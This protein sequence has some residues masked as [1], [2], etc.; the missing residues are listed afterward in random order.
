MTWSGEIA[1]YRVGTRWQE[2]RAVLASHQ[3]SDLVTVVEGFLDDQT[4]DAPG[5]SDHHDL[6]EDGW[7]MAWLERLRRRSRRR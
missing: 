4:A 3:A 1:D 5:G 2:A 7:V 6:Q